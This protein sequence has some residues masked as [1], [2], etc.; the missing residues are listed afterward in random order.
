MVRFST[1]RDAYVFLK[2]YCNCS[3]LNC[4]YCGSNLDLNGEH[5]DI[6]YVSIFCR[7]TIAMV[8][9]DHLILCVEW[10]GEDGKTLKDYGDSTMYGLNDVVIDKLNESDKKWTIDEIREVINEETIE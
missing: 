7:N 8:R 10:T 1:W 6:E 3:C 9:L 5:K 4:I 2:D